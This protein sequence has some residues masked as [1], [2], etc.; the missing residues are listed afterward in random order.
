MAIQ[1][2]LLKYSPNMF[3]KFTNGDP[4]QYLENLTAENGETQATIHA[5]QT[6]LTGV[7]SPDDVEIKNR[8]IWS[9]Q[10]MH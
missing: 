5:S 3:L 6:F 10:F 7:N 8:L 9:V 4:G 2:K 1:S